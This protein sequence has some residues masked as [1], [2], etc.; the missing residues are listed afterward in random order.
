[1]DETD[2]PVLERLLRDPRPELH[3]K[4]ADLLWS[5]ADLADAETKALALATEMPP[6]VGEAGEM[7]TAHG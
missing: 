3:A 7:A 4:L 5:A 6:I 2:L 1:D